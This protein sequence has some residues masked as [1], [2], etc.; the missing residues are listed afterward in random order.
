VFCKKLN[1]NLLFWQIETN[2]PVVLRPCWNF[3]VT[4]TKKEAKNS[5][6]TYIS[7]EEEGEKVDKRGGQ[8]LVLLASSPN[9]IEGELTNILFSCKK[10]QTNLFP[11]NRE[12]S[13][14]FWKGRTRTWLLENN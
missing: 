10:R 7:E 8:L 14:A 4:N 2:V 9:L 11:S 13:F 6:D 12:V 1:E 5:R 3:V